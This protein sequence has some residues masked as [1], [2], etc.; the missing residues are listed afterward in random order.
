MPCADRRRLGLGKPAHQRCA[1]EPCRQKRAIAHRS[2]V[3]PAVPGE[4]E[5]EVDMIERF[6]VVDTDQPGFLGEVL[7][8]VAGN[9]VRRLG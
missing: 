5:N 8:N 7:D 2:V 9:V 6:T 3:D 1:C 4:S